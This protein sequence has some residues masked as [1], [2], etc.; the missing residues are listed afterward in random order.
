M[1]ESSYQ[2][3][4][5]VKTPVLMINGRKDNVGAYESSQLPCYEDL[6]SEIKHHAVLDAGHNPPATEVYEAMNTWLEQLFAGADPRT[7]DTP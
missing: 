2:F 4:P 5:H 3:T 6:G 7:N 1:Q